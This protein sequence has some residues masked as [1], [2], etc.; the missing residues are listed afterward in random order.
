MKSD[1]LSSLDYAQFGKVPLFKTLS[2]DAVIEVCRAGE[3]RKV[4]RGSFYFI[5]GDIAD[6][7]YLLL[8]G[9]IKLTQLNGDGQQILLRVIGPYSLFGLIVMAQV[10]QYPVSA[11]A[12]EDCTALA[13]T[14][15]CLM[16]FVS[17]YP[18][19]ALNA[20]QMMALYTQ[21]FQERLR[22][23]A[24]ERVENRLAHTLLRL[25][26]QSGKKVATGVLIDLRLTRKDLGEMT[27]TTLYTVSRLLR[28]WENQ[29]LITADREHIII[30]NP[31][32]LV[33]I[34]EG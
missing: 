5:Q 8:V 30:C 23:M 11:E 1:K 27:G 33:R 18:V 32:G 31:H 12:L 2:M 9:R 10:E 25:A 7:M 29:G 22:Q 21:E 24:T 14:Q 17:R 13:W 3:V 28:Q 16:Q 20:L 26:S 4:D 6:Q 19:F 15:S 34:A